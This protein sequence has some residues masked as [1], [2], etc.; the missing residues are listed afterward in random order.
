[1]INFIDILKNMLVDDV[2]YM[3]EK[4][5]SKIRNEDFKYPCYSS[6]RIAESEHRIRAIGYLKEVYEYYQDY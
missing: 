4:I 1:M 3:F 2:N 5:T 6:D